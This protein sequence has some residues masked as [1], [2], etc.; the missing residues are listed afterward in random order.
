MARIIPTV[1]ILLSLS[2]KRNLPTTAERITI[3][4]LTIAK[5]R[6]LSSVLLFS[7]INI[8]YSEPKL[9]NPNKKP[10]KRV[11]VLKNFPFMFF[12]KAKTIRLIIN[13]KRKTKL[14]NM[15]DSSE[16]I[17]TV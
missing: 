14:E 3:D 7:A 10:S 11:G 5:T 12:P 16:E 9:T 8:K 17:F 2:L 6:E 15:A 1:F 4:I 13:A